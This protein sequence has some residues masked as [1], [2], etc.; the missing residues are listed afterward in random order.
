MACQECN[1]ADR[2]DALVVDTETTASTRRGH[3]VEIGAVPV[4]RASS[5]RRRR[6]AALF[7]PGVPIPPVA[8]E[9]H[10]IDHPRSPPRPAF[11]R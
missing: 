7:N 10:G 1:A 6:C 11:R 5:L 2:L 3:V 4:D 9:I 8:T